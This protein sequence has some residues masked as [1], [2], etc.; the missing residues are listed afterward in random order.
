M[1]SN[2]PELY[3]INL[4]P[5]AKF[6]GSVNPIIAPSK[7]MMY[8][9]VATALPTAF[10]GQ[11]NDMNH[12]NP[13]YNLTEGISHDFNELSATEVDK[14]FHKLDKQ[15]NVQSLVDKIAA[16]SL[17]SGQHAGL[18]TTLNEGTEGTPVTAWNWCV[19]G[20][21]VAIK[22]NLT[23]VDANSI[24]ISNNHPTTSLV[25]P[26]TKLIASD[27]QINRNPNFFD[28]TMG[29]RLVYNTNYGGQLGMHMGPTCINHVNM[30]NPY[31]FYGYGAHGTC[32]HPVDQ[33][34]YD[35][36]SSSY[37]GN[38]TPKCSNYY[39]G[40]SNCEHLS[41]YKEMTLRPNGFQ[42]DP[43]GRYNNADH[44]H[45]DYIPFNKPGPSGRGKVKKLK[46]S[47]SRK[48]NL[49]GDGQNGG[50][51]ILLLNSNIACKCST[52]SSFKKGW[53][54]SKMRSYS[55]TTQ[56]ESAYDNRYS[57]EKSSD[58]NSTKRDNKRPDHG[59]KGIFSECDRQIVGALFAVMLDN[60]KSKRRKSSS[61]NRGACQGAGEIAKN[62]NSGFV[63][64]AGGAD[65]NA[66]RNKVAT[67]NGYGSVNNDHYHNR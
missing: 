44:E 34:P 42:D 54:A 61:N 56:D 38:R 15:A 31:S 45:P 47:S 16:L 18:A 43:N 64:C 46:K 2:C 23:N 33:L 60:R 49:L 50:S 17:V 14:Q 1:T 11:E 6:A 41:N 13:G 52:C 65:G 35:I 24:F 8:P 32:N 48:L 57:V 51:Y 7:A 55:N 30:S 53:K 20:E 22:K 36:Y 40:L 28:S 39:C 59:A 66:V 26:S 10:V 27:S 63:F 62:A 67:D 19:C 3:G 4:V 12:A 37:C 58:S 5:N 25:Q 29:R 9:V 21:G